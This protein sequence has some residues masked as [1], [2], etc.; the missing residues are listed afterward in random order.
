MVMGMK[1]SAFLFRLD[2]VRGIDRAISGTVETRADEALTSVDDGTGNPGDLGRGKSGA[3]T[4]VI[5]TEGKAVTDSRDGPG[6]VDG[7]R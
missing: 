1:G 3:E 4:L 7:G 2:T 6:E 5:G